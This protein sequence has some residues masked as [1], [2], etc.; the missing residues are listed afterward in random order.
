MDAA[1]WHLDDAG[2]WRKDLF[3]TL[4]AAQVAELLANGYPVPEPHIRVD[5]AP[6]GHKWDCGHHHP[7]RGEAV[8]CKRR[9]AGAFG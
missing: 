1:G 5:F 6:I 8:E 2:D 3:V 4:S 9:Q 7:T